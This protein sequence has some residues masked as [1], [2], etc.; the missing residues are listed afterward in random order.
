[1]KKYTRN[2]NTSMINSM[3]AKNININSI[4]SFPSGVN[5]DKNSNNDEGGSSYNSGNDNDN[6]D[7]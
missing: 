1:M 5:D 2:I 4:S 6:E 7:T 3:R